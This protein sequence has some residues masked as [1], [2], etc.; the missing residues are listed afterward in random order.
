MHR[1]H[2]R[3]SLQELASQSEQERLWGGPTDDSNEMSFFIEVACRLYDD[4]GLSRELE[5]ENPDPWITPTFRAAEAKLSECLN[6]I[7]EQFHYTMD[8]ETVR[9]EK[10][11]R[12]RAAA[13]ELLAIV[14]AAS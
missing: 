8:V 10:M 1:D 7:D 5:L 12:V 4:A 2:V 3:W 13:A 11:Q 9:G 14:N 6:A